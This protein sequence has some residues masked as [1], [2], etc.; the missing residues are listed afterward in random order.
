MTE[1]RQ[2][3]HAWFG[4]AFPTGAFA[5]SHG[6]EAAIA[7]GTVADAGALA[8]WI[9]AVLAQ[10]AGRSDAVLL[11][12]AMRPGADLD[13]LADLA[14]ALA[15]SRERWVETVEQ[16][17]AFAAVSASVW[18]TEAE[19][20][21]L[22][23]AVGAAA[24]ALGDGPEDVVALYLH[25]MAANLVSVAVRF[26][27]LGQTAGQRVLAGLYPVIEATAAA[28]LQADPDDLGGATLAADLAAMRHETM[29]VRIFRT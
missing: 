29:P 8:D 9:G 10:G 17:R 19:P 2:R 21:P 12:A 26:L 14:A 20:R 28:A 1:R 15:T 22:P 25:A 4:A 3:L 13:A 16:G 24:G 7:A 18:G 23:I 5:Y 11:T 27:P 6:L